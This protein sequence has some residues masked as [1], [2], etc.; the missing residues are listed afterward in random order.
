[1]GFVKLLFLKIY[2]LVLT[3]LG[4]VRAS[5]RGNIVSQGNTIEPI[6]VPPMPGSTNPSF[7]F[8]DSTGRIEEDSRL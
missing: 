7:G 8:P 5:V 6:Q 2:R 3:G 4:E 1:M